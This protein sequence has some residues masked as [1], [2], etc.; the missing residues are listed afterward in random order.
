MARRYRRLRTEAALR[1]VGLP[2]PDRI[3]QAQWMVRLTASPHAAGGLARALT[4]RADTSWVK[5]ASGGTEI[6]ALI[7]TNVDAPGDHSLLLHDIPRTAGITSVSAHYLL[8][9]YLGGSTAWPGRLKALSEQQ[10]RQLRPP[11]PPNPTVGRQTLTETDRGLLAALAIDGRTSVTD[12]AR[13]IG[14]SPAT[15]THR[16][17]DLQESGAIFFD[18]EIKPGQ[19]GTTT[20]VLLWMTVTP[21]QLDGVATILTGHGE[22]AVVAATTG[23]TNLVA[24]ALCPDQTALHHYLTRR[25]GTLDAIRTLETAPVLA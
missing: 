7:H 13:T 4:R 21:A 16:L 8:H 17:A 20:E 3:G 23:A 15:V 24:H 19:Y 14:V 1:V 22:L 10:Q 11:R 18:V 25:I 5:L 9:T 12:L 2:D 6:F